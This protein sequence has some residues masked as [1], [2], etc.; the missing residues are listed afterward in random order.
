MTK[1]IGLLKDTPGPGMFTWYVVTHA[2]PGGSLVA[3]KQQLI[4]VRVHSVLQG[5]VSRKRGRGVLIEPENGTGG[6]LLSPRK[7]G[8]I[9]RLNSQGPLPVKTYRKFDSLSG[10]TS[11]SALAP[12]KLHTTPRLM[13]PDPPICCLRVSS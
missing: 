12:K 2:S 9:K 1:I 3:Q 10:A 4:D 8:V 7:R 5:E 13:S 11:N 6:G